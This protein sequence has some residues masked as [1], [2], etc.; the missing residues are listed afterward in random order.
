M[1]VELFCGLGGGPLPFGLRIFTTPSRAG[2]L[3]LSLLFRMPDLLEACFEAC[4]DFTVVVL[5][6]PISSLVF[7]F[8][9]DLFAGLSAEKL[10]CF[11]EVGGRGVLPR[12]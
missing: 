3:L 6:A 12:F 11:A 5:V 4:L 1:A 9:F 2:L 7:M 10:F 8:L